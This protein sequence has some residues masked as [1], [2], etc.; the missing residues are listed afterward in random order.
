MRRWAGEGRDETFWESL[1]ENQP[2]EPPK[3]QRNK[4]Q[5]D[6]SA[7]PAQLCISASQTLVET[8]K[9]PDI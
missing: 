8:V 5:R 4:T 3:P 1:K 9:P 7:L 6:P 2:K